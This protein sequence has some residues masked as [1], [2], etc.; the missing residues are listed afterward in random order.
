MAIVQWREERLKVVPILNANG[1]TVGQVSLLPGWNDIPDESWFEARKW[2][3][4]LI[5]KGVIVE[6]GTV[7]PIKEK[8]VKADGSEEEI[9]EE[10]LGKIIFRD[11]KVDEALATIT[12]TANL[13]T[14]KRWLANDTREEIRLSLT[15]AIDEVEKIIPAKDAPPVARRKLF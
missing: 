3:K 10:K 2:V 7:K 4:D 9:I 5:Q 12:G 6:K 1:V 11:L 13:E 15:K 14:L 8:V